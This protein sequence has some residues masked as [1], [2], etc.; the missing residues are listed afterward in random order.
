MQKSTRACEQCLHI[1][2]SFVSAL[3]LDKLPNLKH[4][5]TNYRTSLDSTL[6]A[7]ASAANQF[8]VAPYASNLH[9]APFSVFSKPLKN[10][11]ALTEAPPLSMYCLEPVT[12]S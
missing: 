1:N 12:A 2:K 4:S 9:A 3:L 5:T 11:P 7:A 8:L 10:C 6:A